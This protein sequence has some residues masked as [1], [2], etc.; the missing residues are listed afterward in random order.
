MGAPME[1]GGQLEGVDSFPHVCPEDG[2]Q[3]QAW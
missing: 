3:V 2:T 1:V